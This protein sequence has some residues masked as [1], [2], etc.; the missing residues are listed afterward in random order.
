M[1]EGWTLDAFWERLGIETQFLQHYKAI[2]AHP[3]VV[4][5]LKQ[6]LPRIA[7]PVVGL[8]FIPD[9]MV[10]IPAV[11]AYPR[12]TICA[13]TRGAEGMIEDLHNAGIRH[14]DL[15]TIE[16]NH[17][18]V[19]DLIASCDVVYISKPG[20]MTRPQLLTL[21]KVKEFREIPDHHGINELRK[22]VAH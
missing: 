17:P 3:S 21:P 11:D 20:Y 2:V 7:P 6:A 16:A 14:L 12:Q 9:P 22:I 5:R 15:R 10:V 18:D 8:D 1:V 19:F 13:T 4:I